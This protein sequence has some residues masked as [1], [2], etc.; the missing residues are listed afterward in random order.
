[1]VSADPDTAIQA[2]STDLRGIMDSR[3]ITFRE[4][5]A[6]TGIHH[7]SLHRIYHGTG[8]PSIAHFIRLRA[9]ISEQCGLAPH[10]HRNTHA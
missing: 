5:A 6:A 8:A 9:W 10:T 7:A 2:L 4:A 1:M 3:G